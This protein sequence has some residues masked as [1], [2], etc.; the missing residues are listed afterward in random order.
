MAIVMTKSE[1]LAHLAEKAGIHKKAAAAVLDEIAA[2][3]VEERKGGGQSMVPGMV[4][5]VKAKHKIR[6]GRNPQTREPV[7]IPTKTVVKFRL[8]KACK[9]SAASSKKSLASAGANDVF[10]TLAKVF[11][12]M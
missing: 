6:T 2:L 10:G 11:S 5:T 1:V 12:N 4:K 9:Y 3:A 8:G 7:K